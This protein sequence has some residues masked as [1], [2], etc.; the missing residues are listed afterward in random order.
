M[1]NRYPFLAA[2]NTLST[3]VR[4]Y[5]PRPDKFFLRRIDQVKV[6]RKKLSGLALY[7]VDEGLKRFQKRGAFL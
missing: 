2:L 4:A 6:R 7:G 1:A 5:N 3:N